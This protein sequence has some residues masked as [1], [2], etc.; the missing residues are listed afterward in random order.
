MS[1]RGIVFFDIDGTLVP[2][3]SSSSFLARR[4]GHQQELDA[5]E[6]R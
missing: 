4:F 3:M 5:A 2:A 6:A 1:P